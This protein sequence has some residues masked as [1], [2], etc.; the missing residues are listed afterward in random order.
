MKLLVE[1]L[2]W[3]R[4]RLKG[5]LAKMLQLQYKPALPAINNDGITAATNDVVGIIA[6]FATTAYCHCR[7]SD[8]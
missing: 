6:L 7:I 5:L 1:N 2:Y 8:A 4:N 3:S